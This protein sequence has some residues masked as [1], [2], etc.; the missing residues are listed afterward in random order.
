[1]VGL[2]AA[3]WLGATAPVTSPIPPAEQARFK[4]LVLEGERQYADGEYGAAIWNFKEADALRLTPEVA[5]NLARTHEKLGDVPMAS[6]YYRLY[7]RRAPEATDALEVAEILGKMLARMEGEGQGLVEIHSPTQGTLTIHGRTWVEFPVALFLPPGEYAATA[8]FP[9]G[10]LEQV[11]AVRTGKTTS[12]QLD[13]VSPPLLDAD[14]PSDAF[15]FAGPSSGNG[16]TVVR[17]SSVALMGLSAAA[18]AVGTAFGVMSRTEGSRL[19]TNKSSLTVTEA[20]AVAKSAGA[21]GM[22]ANLLWAAGGAGLVGGGAL[23]V[24]T[25]PEPGVTAASKE[26]GR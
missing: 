2:I 17:V 10:K 14:G 15:A 5:Y 9:T 19:S 20:N 3:L 8:A 12:V 1:M 26:G 7:L 4:A 13:P 6:Y 25:L 23:F 16:R 24:F 21:K 18:L 22:T 11:I